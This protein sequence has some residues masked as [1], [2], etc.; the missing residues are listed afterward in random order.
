V[1]VHTSASTS[2]AALHAT[3]DANSAAIASQLAGQIYHLKTVALNIED[4]PDN[5]TR[6]LVI[7]HKVPKPTGKD[8]T[9]IVFSIKDRV[10]ALYDVL[11]PF[12]QAKVNL[13]KIE[14][15][16]TKK[17]A[18]EYIFFVDFIGHQAEPKVVRALDGLRQKC[19]HLKILGSYPYG[20]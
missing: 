2:D 16:P 18:W 19:A 1:S 10:G 5:A 14:S 8:K 7:G 15:R 12:S 11:L 3:L 20:V 4:M 9:S 13:T 17:R 6:F